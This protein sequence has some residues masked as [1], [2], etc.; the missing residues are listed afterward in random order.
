MATI[1]SAS[2]TLRSSK[3]SP[4]TNTEVD[5]NFSNLNTAIATGLTAAS[6]TAA[7]VLSKLLTVDG[8][9][10]GLDADLLDGLNSATTNTASTI[11]ARDASGNFSAG[12]I[13]ANLTGTAS[14]ATAL[15][16][17][18]GVAA[19]GTGATDAAGARTNLGLA[20]G[21]NVQA[22]NANLNSIAG[23]TTVAD[24]IGYFT[25]AGTSAIATFTAAGRTIVGSTD[26][27][28]ARTNLGLVIGTD[29]QGYA[30]NLAAISGVSTTGIYVRTA[31]GT[32]AARSIIGGTDITVTQGDGVAGDI[33]I[34]STA[35]PV[36]GT[37]VTVTGKTVSIGQAVATT[38]NVTFG[39]ITGSAIQ[40][41]TILA[42]TELRSSAQVVAYYSSDRKLKENI[43][44]IPNA[45]EKVVHI[46]GKLY[47]WTDQYVQEHGG[48]DGYFMQKSDFGV[49]AQDVQEVFPVAIRTREDGT[50]AVDYQKLCAL[51]FAAIREL[52]T[53]VELLK[54]RG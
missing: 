10:S 22:Y 25:G 2:I 50:L 46:G 47:D 28:N 24:R 13:T 32:A 49:I 11:V 48:E 23:L 12:T 1:T 52:N 34:T 9:G 20:I 51:A 53:E 14:T 21:T 44:D 17:T 40:G 31:A 41:T 33:T 42:T 18:L 3:G 45:L 19:G 39:T 43:T 8:T 29:V 30:A 5:N 7:D 38:S 37:G 35:A 54:N 4:L 26:I 6:Y 15:A 16:A 27:A 36:A